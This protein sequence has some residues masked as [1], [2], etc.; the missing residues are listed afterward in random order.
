[1]AQY[2][3]WYYEDI[4]T[5]PNWIQYGTEQTENAQK[6]FNY[7]TRQGVKPNPANAI[8]GNFQHES[9]L[10]PAQWELGYNKDPA[11][12]YGLG[13]WTPST[14]ITNDYPYPDRLDGDNQ[15]DFLMSDSGQWSTRF[16]NMDT[17]YSSYYEVFVPIIP[18]LQD[19]FENN[20]D[21][22]DDL[23]LAWAVYWERPN[24]EHLA[25]QA[26]K[27]YAD[28]WAE[29]NKAL[30]IWLICKLAEKWRTL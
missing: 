10:N 12:G 15:L 2:N 7:L 18:S 16:V 4:D 5:V 22:V 23:A 20:T 21:S 6:I 11:Y 1:M 30:P 9:Y 25:E 8:I 27:D 19:F 3:G 29:T 13:Q 24:N 17:G 28:H 26:R 14:K